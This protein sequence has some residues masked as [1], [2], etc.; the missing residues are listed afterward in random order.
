MSEISLEIFSIVNSPLL[1]AFISSTDLSHIKPAELFLFCFV[2]L[3]KNLQCYGQNLYTLY[4]LKCCYVNS[5][6][7]E[8]IYT[9][10][11]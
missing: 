2:F 6:T 7:L 1:H 8:V 9:Y 3:S 4:M 10:K 11:N 5:K